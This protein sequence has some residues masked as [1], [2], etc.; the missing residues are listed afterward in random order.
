[1]KSFRRVGWQAKAL[2]LLFVLALHAQLGEW[3]QNLGSETGLRPVF[4]RPMA[5]PYGAID[6]RRPPGPA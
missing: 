6:G 1:M 5:L 4:F 3:V 2:A